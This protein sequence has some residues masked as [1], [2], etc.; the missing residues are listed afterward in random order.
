MNPLLSQNRNIELLG[1]FQSRPQLAVPNDGIVFDPAS[2]G[3]EP[4]REDAD[5][6]GV[7]TV[8]IGRVN[9]VRVHMQIDSRRQDAG[10][11]GAGATI[12]WTSSAWA[13]DKSRWNCDV[14]SR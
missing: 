7:R 5:Y 11:Y 8:F 13:K 3:G 4:I 9:N 10:T 6:A 1:R 14:E 12:F 2:F